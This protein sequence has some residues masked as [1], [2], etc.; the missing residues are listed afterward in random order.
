MIKIRSITLI[1]LLLMLLQSCGWESSAKKGDQS[2]ALG[3][4]FDAASQYR[5][6]YS[7]TPL[8]ER[9]RRAEMAFKMAECYRLTNYHTRA[10][11]GYVNAIRYKYPDSLAFLYLAEA[12]RK[13]GDY[14]S[15]AKN[16]EL[17]LQ[18]YPKHTL[19]INGLA[20]CSLAPEW[21]KSPTRCTV[22][23]FDTFN[24]KRCDFSPAYAG[25]ECDAIYLTSTRDQAKGNAINGITGMKSC[26]ILMAKKDEKKNWKQPEPFE[27]EVNSES[28][29]GACSF[30]A[31][32]R[33]MY[34]TRCRVDAVLPI[35]AE[36]FVSQRT[37]ATWGSPQKCVIT[38]DSL[39]SVAHPAISPDG[40][41][42]YF[43][44]DM[45]GGF[46]GKDI[47]RVPVSN[48]GFGAVENLGEIVNSAADEVFPTFDSN[49]EL[50]FSSNGHVGMG[51][52]DIFSAHQDS[53]GGWHIENLK[54]P[55][56]SSGD[57]FGMTFEPNTQRGFFSS[58]RSDA[59]GWDHIYSFDFPELNYSVTGWVF[60]KEGNP[61]SKA[62][63]SIIGKD[64][65]NL[66][67]SMNGDGSF[68]QKL[69][70]GGSYVMLAHCR[71]YLNFKQELKT[72]TVNE[73][74]SYELEFPLASI[75]KPVLIEH[76]FY[77]FDRASLTKESTKALKELVKMLNDNPNITIELSAHC[78]YI[79]N[80]AYNESLSQQRAESV[81]KFLVSEG[82][83]KERLTAKGYGEGQ[84]K[85]ISKRLAQ[86]H[87]FLKENDTLT[88]DF[89]LKLPKEEQGICNSMNRRTE[90]KVI[91]TTY[92]LY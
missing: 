23:R 77:D 32:G 87:P 45:P 12:Q 53:I 62:T 75:T 49:G 33:T 60:D 39:S 65:T 22:R 7:A 59:R 66:K 74:R 40:H 28:E 55:I 11:S 9:K 91:R 15:A 61:L 50:Y 27:S 48:S 24:G 86:L 82:I 80:D 20:S 57:D 5:K 35:S 34:F 29:E 1:G 64:G 54:Y 8:K 83:E 19:A 17:Y 37:G 88:E 79:G 70:K 4:Y 21:K 89:I 18:S 30:S 67:V 43:T 2:W 51:G 25:K 92:K 44:S 68:T 63:V 52:L 56:N 58:N 47:W 36:I 81:L 31:D 16:Y 3:E 26:D 42:L 38:K 78:D 76:I 84:P 10:M 6:A 69:N 71:G 46:G 72:D 13:G 85:I 41:F 73:N 14:K 90:F